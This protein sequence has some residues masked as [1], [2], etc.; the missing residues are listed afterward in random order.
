VITNPVTV[1]NTRHSVRVECDEDAA[2]W[3][4]KDGKAG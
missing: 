1:I 2:I 3:L 4:L